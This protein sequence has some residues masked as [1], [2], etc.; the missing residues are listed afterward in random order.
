MEVS[1]LLFVILL[2]E[3]VLLVSAPTE[4]RTPGRVFLVPT[5]D[6]FPH[7]KGLVMAGILT[8]PEEDTSGLLAA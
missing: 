8:R 7:Q 5:S 6:S 4:G 3:R 1:F 2:V